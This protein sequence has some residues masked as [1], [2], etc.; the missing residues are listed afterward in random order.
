MG[1]SRV[2]RFL[3]ADGVT[4]LIVVALIAVYAVL[5]TPGDKFD[6][7]SDL[8]AALRS[9]TP[10]VI[11]FYSNNCSI[12]LKSKPEVD[13]IERD[14]QRQA[15][16]LRLNVKDTVGRALAG[17]WGVQ[18]VPTFVVVDQQGAIQYASAGAPNADAIKAAVAELGSAHSAP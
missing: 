16:V 6:T 13:R 15:S 10:T 3:K 4:I 2:V 9:G 18:G 8:E 1:T 11:E 14:L 5:R 12:C 7:I 17:R